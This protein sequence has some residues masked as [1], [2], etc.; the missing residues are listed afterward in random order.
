MFSVSYNTSGLAVCFPPYCGL[1]HSKG[2]RAMVENVC[3]GVG[4]GPYLQDIVGMTCD[5]DQSRFLQ[6]LCEC[7]AGKAFQISCIL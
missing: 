7:A 6:F 1:H 2:M 3:G 4:G 5:V